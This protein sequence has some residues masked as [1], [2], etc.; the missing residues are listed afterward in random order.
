M[1]KKHIKKNLFIIILLFISIGFAVL[2][3]N[4]NVKTNIAL[5]ENSF[6]IIFKDIKITGSSA[7]NETATITDD[8]TIDFSGDFNKP[9]DYIDFSFY[10]VNAGTLDGELSAITTNLTAEQEEY[11]NYSFKYE[12]NNVDV[13][14]NDY[15]SAGRVKKVNAHF[16]YKEDIDNFIDIETLS[17]EINM[18][19]IQPKVMLTT[20][21]WNYSFT[22]MEEYF[23]APKTGTYKIELWG[24]EGGYKANTT[25]ILGGKGG[26]VKGEINLNKNDLLY[27]YVGE[28]PI[29]TSGSCFSTNE[30]D[31]FNGQ[32]QGSCSG[33]GGATDIRLVNGAW[34]SFTSLKSRIAIAGGGGGGIYEGT[35]GSAGGLKAYSAV[36]NGA[37]FD[38]PTTNV[39]NQTSG[40]GFGV[41]GRATTN[42]GG[43]YFGGY[44]GS[45]TNAGGGSSYISGHNGC[46]AIEESST[47]TSVKFPTKN[48]VACTNG[49]TD[50]ECSKH[51]SGKVFTNTVMIDGNGYSWTTEKGSE[52][53]GMPTHDGTG[54]MTGNT[55]D[56]FA[57]I[58]YIG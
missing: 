48:G 37:T 1:I 19:F 35:G 52:V 21:V 16:E 24:A 3:S 10:I 55:G 49:T 11:I 46:V 28:H 27:V 47:S 15:F 53:V 14:V 43:G 34:H 33:G 4:I 56:G 13:A 39:A 45:G 17:L 36:G 50:I 12:V 25:N 7:T 22:D 44:T 26:Y 41:A 2:T 18:T 31:S 42:G 57:K 9:G 29:Y 58:T 32:S 23:I 5:R 6:N 51:Y 40:Y 30:N 20:T 54:T 38:P 8:T